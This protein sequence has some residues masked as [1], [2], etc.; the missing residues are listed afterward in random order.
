MA[1]SDKFMY[2]GVP[3]SELLQSGT[4]GTYPESK[5]KDS[6]TQARGIQGVNGSSNIAG[7]IEMSKYFHYAGQTTPT[8]FLTKAGLN[9][10]P[11]FGTSIGSFYNSSAQST[12]VIEI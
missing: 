3:L 2:Q 9:F 1:I 4:F 10:Y 12:R 7:S 11:S 8:Y 5:Y 6:S